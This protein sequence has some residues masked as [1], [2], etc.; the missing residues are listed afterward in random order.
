MYTLEEYEL[1]HIYMYP[2][3]QKCSL[4]SSCSNIQE[5]FYTWPGNEANRRVA[6]SED[7]A[8][9]FHS[10]KTTVLSKRST[11]IIGAEGNN[12]GIASA[13]QL[14]MLCAIRF[15]KDNLTSATG[16]RMIGDCS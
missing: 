9:K 5:E 3:R 15:N 13:Q 10:A 14:L 1:I 7:E 11:L 4:V 8:K 2:L 6:K 12:I 16:V